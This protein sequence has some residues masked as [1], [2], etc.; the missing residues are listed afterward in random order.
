MVKMCLNDWNMYWIE[1]SCS[2][3]LNIYKIHYGICMLV[4]WYWHDN[5]EHVHVEEGRLDTELPVYAS[6][7]AM[8]FETAGN[9]E[10]TEKSATDSCTI[11][12]TT[13]LSLI[14]CDSMSPLDGQLSNYDLRNSNMYVVS[15]SRLAITRKSFFLDLLLLNRTPT[16]VSKKK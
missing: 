16:C 12:Y 7:K 13:G 6:R 14:L 5:L 11:L 15:S 10:W 3:M 2:Y 9:C 1:L 8:Y 4:M